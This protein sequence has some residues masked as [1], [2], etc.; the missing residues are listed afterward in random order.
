MHH[1]EV[2]DQSSRLC[3]VYPQ[4]TQGP[5]LY[6]ITPTKECRKARKIIS[7]ICRGVGVVMFALPYRPKVNALS[8]NMQEAM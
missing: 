8:Q 3:Y 5:I 4:N 6:S 1:G 7:I 2:S